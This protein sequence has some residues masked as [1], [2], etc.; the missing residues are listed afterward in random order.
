[1]DDTAK[2]MFPNKFNILNSSGQVLHTYHTAGDG[3][4]DEAKFGGAVTITVTVAGSKFVVDAVSQGTLELTEGRTYVF[5]L[6]D[7]SVSGHPFRLSSTSNGTHSGG[8]EYLHQVSKTGTGGSAGDELVI[9]VP[10]NAPTLY[11]YCA[12]HGGMGG[13]LNTNALV[14]IGRG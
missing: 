11:Y 4:G 9:R 14:D 3:D 8:T 2:H 13:T 6:S 12:S 1:M 10:E 5:D 7:S